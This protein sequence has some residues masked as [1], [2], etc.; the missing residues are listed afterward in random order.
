MREGIRVREWLDGWFQTSED[1]KRSDNA[2]LGKV[3]S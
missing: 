1:G 2:L 3:P